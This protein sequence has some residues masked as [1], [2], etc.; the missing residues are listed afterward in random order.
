M[1]DVIGDGLD[2]FINGAE[3]TATKAT[4]RDITKETLNHV[5]PGSAGRSEV[6]VEAIVAF[7]PCLHLRMFVRRIVVA[8]DMNLF[9]GWCT[10]INQV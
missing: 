2:K 5:E 1:R 9:I 3:N 8:N 7:H 6:N 4:V 10:P